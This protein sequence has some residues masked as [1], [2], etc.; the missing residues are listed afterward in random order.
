MLAQTWDMDTTATSHVVMLRIEPDEGPASLVFTTEGC[1]GQIGINEAGIAVGINNLTAADGRPG[2]TWPFVVRKA[3]AQTSFEAAVECVLDAPLAGGHNY[4][5]MDRR[6][7]GVSIEA[8]PTVRHV[9]TVDGLVGHTNHCLAPDTKAVEGWRPPDL[10]ESSRRR[11]SEAIELLSNGDVDVEQVVTMLRH[12][13]SICRR[14]APPHHYETCGAV[15]MRPSTG[16]MWACWGIPADNDFEHF[17][18]DPVP[19]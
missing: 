10:Q 14:A 7:D 12:E 16:E 5:M 3:L 1:I 15:V 6:G 9:T 11:L 17:T 2:V 18:I 4:L 19:A 13:S 8:M